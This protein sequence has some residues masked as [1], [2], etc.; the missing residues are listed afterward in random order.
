MCQAAFMKEYGSYEISQNGFAV[1]MMEDA[2]ISAKLV[3]DC[4]WYAESCHWGSGYGGSVA[5][6]V[7]QCYLDYLNGGRV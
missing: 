3:T 4:T 7:A 2:G 5:E 6:A 1:Q